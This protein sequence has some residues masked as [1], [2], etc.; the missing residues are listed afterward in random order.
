M[1]KLISIILIMLVS[2]INIFSEIKQFELT[3]DDPKIEYQSKEYY[4][5]IIKKYIDLGFLDN[6]ERDH[7]EAVIKFPEDIDLLLIYGDILYARGN[8]KEEYNYY[9]KLIEKYPNESK[10]FEK[11][12][13]SDLDLKKN[14]QYLSDLMMADQLAPGNARVLGNI[15]LYYLERNNYEKAEIYL[16]KSYNV[17]S[18]MTSTINNIASLFYY[19]KDYQKALDWINTSIRIND[20][21]S[22]SYRIRSYIYEKLGRIEDS[23]SDLSKVKYGN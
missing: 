8:N 17:D 7:R 5:I 19:K 16:F 23:K 13:Y 22:Y 20:Q 11:R 9:T 3:I 2:I 10:I 21:N 12:S 4:Q 1:I 15:G 14:E 18:K 6:A